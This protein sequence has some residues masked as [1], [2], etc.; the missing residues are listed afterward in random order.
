MGKLR[1]LF[2]FS[3]VHEFYTTERKLRHIK[4]FETEIWMGNMG[5]DNKSRGE[6]K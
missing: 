3:V 6:G 4:E 5:N 2:Y 1:K